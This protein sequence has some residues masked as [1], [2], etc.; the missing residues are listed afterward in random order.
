M[1]SVGSVLPE[2]PSSGRGAA[3]AACQEVAGSLVRLVAAA[4][5]RSAAPPG[6]AGFA[7]GPVARLSEKR[8]KLVLTKKKA[9]FVKQAFQS[10]RAETDPFLGSNGSIM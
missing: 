6:P 9:N 4:P 5:S 8:K 1:C 7:C 2:A 3:C 10:Y